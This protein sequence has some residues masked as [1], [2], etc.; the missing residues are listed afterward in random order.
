[1]P[2][3]ASLGG[4][5]GVVVGMGKTEF[6]LKRFGEKLRHLLARSG[7]LFRSFSA[8][9]KGGRSGGDRVFAARKVLVGGRRE[10]RG[11]GRAEYDDDEDWLADS[12]Y[13]GL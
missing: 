10:R 11:R 5:H 1:M 13:S 7:D 4:T 12:V 6:H 2:Y 8:S 9:A 3:P